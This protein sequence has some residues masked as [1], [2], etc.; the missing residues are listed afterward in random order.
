MGPSGRVHKDITVPDTIVTW[1]MQAVAIKHITGLGLATPLRTVGKRHYFI[2]L[3]IPC[4]A[5]KRGEQVDLLATDFN[6]HDKEVGGEGD[7]GV[8]TSR[9]PYTALPL[10]VSLTPASRPSPCCS[11]P[12]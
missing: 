3:K 7:R 2:S 11:R 12:L 8:R 5:V 10:P 6:Y 1:I 9:L 4:S